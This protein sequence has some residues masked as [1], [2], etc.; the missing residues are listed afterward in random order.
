MITFLSDFGLKDPYVGI[1]KGV[2]LSINPSVE[3]VDLTHDIPPQDILQ[4]A[5]ALGTSYHFYPPGTIFLAVVDPGVGSRRAGMVAVS[6]RYTFVAPD[7]GILSL[8]FKNEKKVSCYRLENKKFFRSTV[9]PTFHA[10]DIFGP[11]AARLSLGARFDEVGPLYTE[12]PVCLWPEPEPANGCVKG[13]VVYVDR[14]GTL[15]TNIPWRLLAR[16][17]DEILRSWRVEIGGRWVRFY[18]TY[19]DVPAGDLLAVAGSA[20]YVEISVNMGSAL[21]ELNSAPGDPVLVKR[22]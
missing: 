20:G 17:R 8:V 5:Y 1:V 16:D 22:C 4:A 21:D 2:I 14:F 19:C 18:N 9:D 7:N 13:Q 15:I 6:E 10:R 11:V 3:I 12:S